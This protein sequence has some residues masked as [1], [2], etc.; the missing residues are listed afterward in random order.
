[1]QGRRIRIIMLGVVAVVGGAAVAR[2]AELYGTD[3]DVI[4]DPTTLGLFGTLTLQGDTLEF[5]PNNFIAV[6]TNGQGVVTPTGVTTAS[7]IQLIANPG[8]HFGSLQLAEVGDYLLSGTGSSVSLSGELIAFDGDSTAN[9]LA[10]YTTSLITSASSLT[11]KTGQAV[12]WAAGATIDNGTAPAYGG[13]G[14]WLS[15]AET[16]D[17]SIENLLSASTD[18]ADSEALIQKKAAFGGVELTVTPVPLPASAWLFGSGLLGLAGW[19]AGRQ[20][21]VVRF[22]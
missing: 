10:T 16:V 17:V 13:S 8:F 11:S 6:S 5:T 3:F 14:A 12:N 19:R 1:M 9:P 22:A 21:K 20:Q 4:Y 15:G 7:G 2:S 18:S